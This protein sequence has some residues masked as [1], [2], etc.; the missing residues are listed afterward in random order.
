MTA[1]RPSRTSSPLRFSSFS[2]SSPMSRAYLLMTPVERRAEAAQ[3][4]ATLVGVDVVGKGEHRLLV[5][6]VPLHRDLDRALVGLSLEGDDLAVDRLFV[7]IEVGDEVGD[8]ALVVE[9]GPG[10]LATLVDDRDAQVPGQEGRLAQT[11]LER[12]EVEIER[13]EDVSVGQE[14]DRR[15]VLAGRLAPGDRAQW[16]RRARSSASRRSRRVAPRR[17]AAL[18]AR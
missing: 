6:G 13:L 3:V 11:L 15:A 10:A 17:R 14:R 16:E 8:A 2:L 4:R 7:L 12:V 9:R 1:V 18:R 5:G